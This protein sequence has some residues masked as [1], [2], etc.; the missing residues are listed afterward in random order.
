MRDY[1]VNCPT[2]GYKGLG[3]FFQEGLRKLFSI[4]ILLGVPQG[5]VLGLLLFIIYINNLPNNLASNLKLYA[6]DALLYRT[7][8]NAT[9]MHVFQSDLNAL[10]HW[11][12]IW[13]MA[14]NPSKCK[15][16][17]LSYQEN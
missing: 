1:A 16:L 9:D 4:D 14:F 7:I 12:S 10:D 3:A 13:L 5:S 8:H 17:Q 15:F 11:A 2:T 6:D